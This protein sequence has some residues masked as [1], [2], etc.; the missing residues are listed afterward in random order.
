MS[1]TFSSNI[2]CKF[3]EIEKQFLAKHYIDGRIPNRQLIIESEN[4]VFADLFML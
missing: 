2:D 3:L 1:S 4:V